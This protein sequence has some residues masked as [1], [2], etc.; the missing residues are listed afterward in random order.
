M[1]F[2]PST[3]APPNRPHAHRE[4]HGLELQPRLSW[5]RI[6]QLQMEALQWTKQTTKWKLPGFSGKPNINEGFNMF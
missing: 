1:L 2:T 5:D 4:R 3:E 6:D